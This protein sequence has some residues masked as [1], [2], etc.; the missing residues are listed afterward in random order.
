MSKYEPLPPEDGARPRH[1]TRAAT[2]AK[3][4]M[5]W[6]THA[7]F[8]L[9]SLTLLVA[10]YS[11]NNQSCSCA[12]AEPIIYSPAQPA[13]EYITQQFHGALNH[14]SAYKG[15][16]RKELDDAWDALSSG[17]ILPGPTL[18]ISEEEL[19]LI[20]KDFRANATVKI[21]DEFGGGYFATLEVFHNLHCLNLV[22]MATYMEHYE[23]EHAFGDH[24]LRNHVDH[25][26]DMIRQRLT[27]TADIGLVTAVWVDGYSEPY[28]DFST[29]HQCRNFEM[30]RNWAMD[31]AL[32]VS[33]EEVVAARGA[34]SLSDTPK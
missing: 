15:T 25:C 22:R 30:I 28:P 14:K 11:R 33:M 5:L 23:K 18:S 4:S 1:P 2:F 16:P 27:C 21:P 3:Q 26:I 17:S 7:A 34:V 6:I 24:W 12:P 19:H 20:G 8:F 31:R 29:R 10:S 13:V 32:N 9:V